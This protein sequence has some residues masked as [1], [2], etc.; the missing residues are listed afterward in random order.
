MSKSSRKYQKNKRSGSKW[1]QTKRSPRNKH[2][3]ES[4][5]NHDDRLLNRQKWAK[6][7]TVFERR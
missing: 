7:K 5:K 3:F 6:F 4:R 2:K 1:V